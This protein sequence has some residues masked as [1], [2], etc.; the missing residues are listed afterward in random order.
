MNKMQDNHK[1]A[2]TVNICFKSVAKITYLRTTATKNICF[3]REI[4]VKI[5]SGNACYLSFKNILFSCLLSE[6]SKMKIS[7][8]LILPVIL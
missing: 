5:N 6:N 2:K 8:T 1:R 4:T 7:G 3:H